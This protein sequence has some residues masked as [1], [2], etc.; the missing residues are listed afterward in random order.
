MVCYNNLPLI[1]DEKNLLKKTY[2]VNISLIRELYKI[3]RKFRI[4]NTTGYNKNRHS[5]P[6]L[7]GFPIQN[8]DYYAFSNIIS[9]KKTGTR[10]I[11]NTPI[12]HGKPIFD[13]Y[14]DLAKIIIHLQKDLLWNRI[15]CFECDGFKIPIQASYFEMSNN[16]KKV[17]ERINNR[18]K[19]SVI[20]QNIKV[21]LNMNIKIKIFTKRINFYKDE[22]RKIKFGQID[23]IEQLASTINSSYCS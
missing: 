15:H 17:L 3:I 5:R 22:I 4:F 9:R 2:S 21:Q 20:K 14:I 10:K 16:T 23:S 7:I 1:K 19:D 18:C 13:R 8:K 11:V 12:L 6:M